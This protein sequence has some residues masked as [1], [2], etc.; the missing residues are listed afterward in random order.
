MKLV[1]GTRE[2]DNFQLDAARSIITLLDDFRDGS[3]CYGLSISELI[4]KK[5]YK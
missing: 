5:K 4:A 3:L 2:L 1:Q